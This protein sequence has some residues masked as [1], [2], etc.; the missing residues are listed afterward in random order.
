MNYVAMGMFFLG[1][2]AFANAFY[3][4]TDEDATFSL[5]LAPSLMLIGIGIKVLFI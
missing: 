3:S 1:L 2:L 4:D 5:S